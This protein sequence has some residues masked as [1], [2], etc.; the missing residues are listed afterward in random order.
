VEVEQ[1]RGATIYTVDNDVLAISGEPKRGTHV[2]QP[3]TQNS[4]I[5]GY[6]RV[7][8]GEP[9]TA[10]DT[11]GLWLSLLI[12]L[13]IPPMVVALRHLPWQTLVAP[14][15]TAATE[16]APPEPEPPP[17]PTSEL[18]PVLAV[19]LFNQLS[20][21]PRIRDA[22]L[23]R[24]VRL[25]DA[26][27]DLYSGRVATL[28]GTGVLLEFEGGQDAERP[29]QVLC[30][31]FLLARLLDTDDE[32]GQFRFGLHQAELPRGDDLAPD[33][34]VVQDAALLSAVARPGSI[35]VSDELFVR[36]VRPERVCSEHLSNPLLHQLE[37]T[38]PSAWLVSGLDEPHDG[39]IEQQAR[40]LGYSAPATESAST[41]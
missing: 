12:G 7:T 24:A 5:V 34:P 16:P 13:L 4:N 40:E 35:V 30:A 17:P 10:P 31:A 26:V 28:P 27:T 9:P 39:V 20:L 25:A 2:I 18:R 15:P 11:G 23:G 29:F 21:P 22:E 36:V 37:S 33:D 41:F 38:E 8:L 3:I 14:R 1:V 19:N 32:P 6:V